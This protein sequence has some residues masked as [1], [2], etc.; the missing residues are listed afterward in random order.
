MDDISVRHEF[1]Y[2]PTIS[3]Y[4]LV[5]Q[6]FR[7]VILYT[8]VI[9]HAIIIIQKFLENEISTDHIHSVRKTPFLLHAF[10][11]NSFFLFVMKY[12]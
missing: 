9:I 3:N 12:E 1:E 4:R 5:S 6:Y 11:F 8:L 7:T 10:L 2:L